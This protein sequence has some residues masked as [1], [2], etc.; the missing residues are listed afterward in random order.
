MLLGIAVAVLSFVPVQQLSRRLRKRETGNQSALGLLFI[1]LSEVLSAQ[2]IVKAFTAEPYERERFRAV[3]EGY[4]VGNRKSADLRA[5]VQPVVE[6]IGTAGAAALMYLGGLQ[7]IEGHWEAESFFTVLFL[8]Y[9]S[10]ATM[11]RLADTNSKLATGLASADRVATLLMAEP[12]IVDVPDA[13]EL[14]PFSQVI[15]YQG[16]AY[17]HDPANPVLRDINFKL[18]K[19]QTFALVGPTGSGKSTLAD[20]LPR[21]FDVDQG[22]VLFDGVDLRHAKTVSL[23]QQIAIVTQDTMLFGDTIA[24][25]IAYARPGTPQAAI[26]RAA[27]AAHAH[28]FITALPQG[29]Q[30][31]VGERGVRLS[32]GERQ[33]IAIARALLKDAPILIL[34]EATSALDSASEALVQQAITNLKAGRTT[35]VIAHRLST[36]RDADQILV[37]DD[38]R[39]V[40]RGR[41]AELLAKGGLYARL[42]ALQGG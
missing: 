28:D 25:N 37:L 40:E 32:G 3:N 18:P 8:L 12:E 14:R 17:D 33:R 9:Q 30:T 2:K 42:V 10:I 19:G 16:V 27:R 22:R 23:R 29:Y 31:H 26:E 5:R 35:L 24:G 38:G 41:H 15:E 6:I 20:L 39:I 4:N 13:K 7:V 21:F 34:D 36:I 11:R 1:N